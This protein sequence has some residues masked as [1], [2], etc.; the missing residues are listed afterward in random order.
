MDARARMGLRDV[1]CAVLAVLLV[2]Q[3]SV[4]GARRIDVLL[5]G[6]VMPEHPP[7]RW[8]AIEPLVDYSLV[9]TGTFRAYSFNRD[10]ARRSVRIYFPRGEKGLLQYDFFTYRGV[11]MESLTASQING[12]RAATVD[13]GAGAF[14]ELGGITKNWG[15]GVN[16][17]W[18]DSTLAEVFPND[19]AA[20]QIWETYRD[21]Y[22]TLPYRVVVNQDPSLP[23]VISMFL[24]LGVEDVRGYWY[25]VLLT[26]Q[27]GATTWAWM[28]GNYPGNPPWLLSWTFGRA[29]TWSVAD[30]LDTPW[31]DDAFNVV[32]ADGSSS[33]QR[34]GLD[35]IMNLI[36]HS[37]GRP[38]PEDILAV[39][40]LRR[41]FQ[42]IAERFS[43]LASLSDFVER[44]GVSSVK[45][46]SE[47]DLLRGIVNEAEESYLEGDYED[48][49]ARIAEA[50]D[51]L[52]DLEA[53]AMEWKDQALL[54]V[55]VTEWAAVA[56]TL[57]LA[58]YFLYAAMLRRRFY[59]EVGSTRAM[60]R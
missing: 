59:R 24:P 41:D 32:T 14:L 55:Y 15:E 37:L 20:G 51:G 5:V 49:G 22:G 36:L 38:L 58:G 46:M 26:P 12:L 16:W 53:R 33:D 25:S 7:A 3:G 8:F 11:Y 45:L 47:G 18:V 1:A 21:R 31:W 10:E 35:I 54:W 6:K 50:R 19:P 57:T 43:T 44:F 56:G 48:A 17:P 42:L 40:A 27:Q 4:A 9:P 30:S 29:L 23:P 39:N 60:T 34:Y 2:S 28:K 52:H 13:G